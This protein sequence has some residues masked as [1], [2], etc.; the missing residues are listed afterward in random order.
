MNL[1]NSRRTIYASNRTNKKSHT[2]LKEENPSKH[3][4]EHKR[5]SPQNGVFNPRLN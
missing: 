5:L 3:F 4:K 2:E 1:N